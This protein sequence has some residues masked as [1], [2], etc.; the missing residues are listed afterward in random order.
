MTIKVVSSLDRQAWDAYVGTCENTSLYHLYG[1]NKVFREAFGYETCYLVAESDTGVAGVLPLFVINNSVLGG[2]YVSSLPRGVCA[3]DV[4]T[5]Q[6]LI[7]VAIELAREREAR[8]DE[9]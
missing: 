7:Q 5:T 2:N 6:H 1:W 4:N 3:N 9:V 8:Y